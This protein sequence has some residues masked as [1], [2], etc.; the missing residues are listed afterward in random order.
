MIAQ[1]AEMPDSWHTYGACYACDVQVV[2]CEE[3][4]HADKGMEGG[5]VP[6]VA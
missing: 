3:C 6:G 4:V 5:K 2:G 1:V